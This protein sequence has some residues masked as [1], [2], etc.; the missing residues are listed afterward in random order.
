MSGLDSVAIE[1]DAE[2][3]AESRFTFLDPLGM[4]IEKKRRRLVHG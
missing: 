4:V 2:G 3:A 1:V